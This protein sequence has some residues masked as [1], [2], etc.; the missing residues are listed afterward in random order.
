LDIKSGRGEV[1]RVASHAFKEEN[2]MSDGKKAYVGNGAGDGD[3]RA[4]TDVDGTI[5][6][7]GAGDDILR[8]GRYDDILNGG[9]GDDQLFG[10]A[11]AD[12]FRFF[13]NQIDGPL[14]RDDVRDLD[15]GT[16]D[17]LV[18]GNFAAGTFVDSGNVNAFN[19]GSDA[20]INSLEGLF[21]ADQAS[22]SV[23]V[24]RAAA[25]NNNLLVTITNAAGQ[26]ME[27]E[28]TNLYTQYLAANGLGV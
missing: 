8:G 23:T 3:I 7:G 24:T 25:G 2:N 27:I 19:N 20:I 28:L 17:I 12:Q 21:A 16:G 13:G 5:L 14:D 18:L 10:G 15:F 4:T 22:D 1:F 11:G 26:V 9:S 6:F